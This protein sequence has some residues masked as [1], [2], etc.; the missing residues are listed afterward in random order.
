MQKYE[1]V[2]RPQI[3]KIESGKDFI[4]Y[5]SFGESLDQYSD[6][7]PPNLRCHLRF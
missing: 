3:A 7:L 2:I 6:L 1:Y 4:P 5:F